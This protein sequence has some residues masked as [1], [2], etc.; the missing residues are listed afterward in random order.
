MDR[1]VEEIGGF[2][3]TQPEWDWLWSTMWFC[4]DPDS[5]PPRDM[6]GWCYSPLSATLAGA[7]ELGR[8]VNAYGPALS[9]NNN[10][11]ASAWGAYYQFSGT[12]VEMGLA[13]QF[14]WTLAFVAQKWGGNSGE[15]NMAGF[16][17]YL[18]SQHRFYYNPNTENFRYQFASQDAMDGSCPT[19]AQQEE[20]CAFVFTSDEAGGNRM[21]ADGRLIAERSSG[22]VLVTK[23]NTIRIGGH[24]D[25]KQP[26]CWGGTIGPFVLSRHAWSHA[27]AAQWSADPWGFLRPAV[28]PIPYVIGCPDGRIRTELAS[29]GMIRTERAADGEVRTGLAAAGKIDSGL[30]SEGVVRTALA[31]DGK[32]RTCQRGH[33]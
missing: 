21:Y 32:L 19:L 6:G 14:N 7:S 12:I 30:A 18:W 31:A 15:I 17:A 4:P 24:P 8:G 9:L 25:A 28:H 27:Q 11:N 23:L 29:D 13:P 33:P 26:K 5:W 22:S 2:Y 16:V 1:M 20:P 3:L 10:T